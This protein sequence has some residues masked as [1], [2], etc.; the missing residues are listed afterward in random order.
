MSDDTKKV[1]RRRNFA[2]VVY[3]ESAPDGW[4]DKL[5][6]LAIPS[7]VSPEHNMDVDPDGVLKKAHYHVL[8]KFEG[9]KS[10][11]QVRDL[12]SEFGGVGVEVVESARG[13]A[14]YMCHL[15]NPE[16]AQ[17]KTDDVISLAGAD[18]FEEINTKLDKYTAVREM[19]AFCRENKIIVYADLLEYAAE[20]REDWFRI[21]CD[22]GTYVVK[23]Y[24][25]SKFWGIRECNREK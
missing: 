7:Y 4:M 19:L 11:D 3:P 9:K 13:Y 1:P 21:L 25:K 18:Y 6:E 12:V 24:L 2:T 10:L 15:D 23:E 5:R 8:L 14:R 20:N 17:Y 16:K 22:S